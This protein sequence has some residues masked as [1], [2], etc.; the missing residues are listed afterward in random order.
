TFEQ[1]ISAFKFLIDFTYKNLDYDN[2]V[3]YIA[4][5]RCIQ[6]W[7]HYLGFNKFNNIFENQYIIEYMS[8][9]KLFPDNILLKGAEN[10]F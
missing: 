6:K 5:I 4:N 7:C 2:L 10:I 9:Q 3:G 1:N 8:R